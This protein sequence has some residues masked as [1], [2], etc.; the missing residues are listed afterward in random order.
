M[1]RSWPP[2]ILVVRRSRHPSYIAIRL[3]DALGLLLSGHAT[4]LTSCYFVVRRS[5]QHLQTHTTSRGNVF[6]SPWAHDSY[7]A[8]DVF[9]LK[10]ACVLE[11]RSSVCDSAPIRIYGAWHVHP[12]LRRVY[13]PSRRL[14]YLMIFPQ[15][16]VLPCVFMVLGMT[17]LVTFYLT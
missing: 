7:P 12:T 9:A 17:A 16:L 6:A 15:V 4:F 1:R 3:C 5:W 14:T 13:S 11:K 10:K 8:E 2:A